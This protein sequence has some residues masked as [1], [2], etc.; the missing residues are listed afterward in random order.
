V[1]TCDT[2]GVEISD[3]AAGKATTFDQQGSGFQTRP[4]LESDLS[5]SHVPVT[6]PPVCCCGAFLS[7]TCRENESILIGNLPRREQ[8][9][10]GA[11][12]SRI[13]SSVN[14]PSESLCVCSIAMSDSTRMPRGS[15]ETSNRNG[16]ENGGCNG[17]RKASSHL[18]RRFE[19]TTLGD[20]T[21]ADFWRSI[22][23][24]LSLLSIDDDDD[25]EL[26][27]KSTPQKEGHSDRSQL[28]ARRREGLL[29]NGYAAVREAFLETDELFLLQALRDGIEHLSSHPHLGIVPAPF[30]FLYDEAWDLAV[31]SSA[32]V[33]APCTSQQNHFNFDLLAW[34]IERKARLR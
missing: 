4:V 2:V 5:H 32:R 28:G 11:Q 23:P 17:G 9:S 31:K 14:P 26:A 33:L 20:W 15:E 24:V 18:R 34:H 27:S 29:R 21:T 13:V 7:K 19:E 3:V 12:D 16:A 30:V 6:L 8:R 10:I 25:T 22:C 1:N